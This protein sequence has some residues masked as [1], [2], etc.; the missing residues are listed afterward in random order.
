MAYAGIATLASYMFFRIFSLNKYWS[1]LV[2]STLFGIHPT[3]FTN[4]ILWSILL[5]NTIITDSCPRNAWISKCQWGQLQVQF[6]LSK[7]NL[8][9]SLSFLFVV[10]WHEKYKDNWFL[11]RK[12]WISMYS[13]FDK[14]LKVDR[15]F[16]EYKQISDIEK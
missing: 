9:S 5:L 11:Y 15:L 3:A 13:S 16:I 10:H 7:E 2:S 8:A 12:Q 6:L 1:C 4:V 14:S